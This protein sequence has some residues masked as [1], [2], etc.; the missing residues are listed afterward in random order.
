MKVEDRKWMKKWNE[1]RE[2]TEMKKKEN[3]R[4]QKM[5]NKR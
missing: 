4:R 2:N 1:T 5:D 3:Y